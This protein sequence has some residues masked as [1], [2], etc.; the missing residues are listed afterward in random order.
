MSA[1]D[2]ARRLFELINRDRGQV[3]AARSSTVMAARLFEML[4]SHPVLSV[5]RAMDL[6]A[7]SRPTA[8][9]A[10]AALVDAGV[11][12]ETSARKRDRTFGYTDYLELLR[13]GTDAP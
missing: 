8:S 13:V 7:T 9:K 12:V 10:I 3:L 4:P 1:V 2:T 11:L 6:L 5:A